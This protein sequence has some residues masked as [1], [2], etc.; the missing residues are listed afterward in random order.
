[1]S[2]AVIIIINIHFASDSKYYI[3]KSLIVSH[4]ISC[5]LLVLH[6]KRILN[7]IADHF[8]WF[9]NIYFIIVYRNQVC[10]LWGKLHEKI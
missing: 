2:F 3:D 4:N 10:D 9:F 1:M 6:Y 7:I 8:L 5:P